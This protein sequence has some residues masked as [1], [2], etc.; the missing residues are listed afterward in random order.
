ME[1]LERECERR[2]AE[3][4]AAGALNEADRVTRECAAQLWDARLKDAAREEIVKLIEEATGGLGYRAE[5]PLEPAQ[6]VVAGTV[7][8]WPEAVPEGGRV[9]EVGTGIGRTCYVVHYARRPALYVT[10]DI[11]LPILAVA[12]YGNPVRAF[13]DA[14]WR[15]D[16]RVVL[17]D[18]L[19]VARLLPSGAF[20]HVIHDGGPNP[21]RNPRLYS[22]PMFAE[23]ARLLKP[24]GTLSVFAGRSRRGRQLVYEGLRSAGLEIVGVASFPDSP[25]AVYRARKPCP[26][27]SKA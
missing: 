2:V 16:V 3:R 15:D 8:A 1:A 7:I 22:A 20:D 18:A 21:L 19:E 17:G 10:V 6:M 4:L 11:S 24:C 5:A 25:A 27:G 26:R 9:F 14:L 13:R 23:L 12:L